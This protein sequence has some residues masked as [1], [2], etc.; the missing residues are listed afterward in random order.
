MIVEE[1]VAKA[2]QK[3]Q[4]AQAVMVSQET[5]AV[6]FENDRLKSAASSQRTKI[7]LRVIVDGRG[8]A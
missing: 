8:T 7:D 4:A 5:S 6:D 2:L 3:A 1:I